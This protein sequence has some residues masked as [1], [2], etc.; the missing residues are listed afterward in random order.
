MQTH[1]VY[2]SNSSGLKVGITRGQEPITRWIDQGAIGA[3]P[4]GTVSKRL[5]AG[6][7]ETAL[8]QYVSDKTNWRIMLKGQTPSLDLYEE[9]KRFLDLIPDNHGFKPSERP[10]VE[11]RYPV[12]AYPEKIKSF[13]FDKAPLVEGTLMGIKGQYLILDTGV[14]N[15][16]KFSGYRVEVS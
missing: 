6:I 5:E 15:I 9:R 8:K 11:I 12:L 2:L 1:T 13:N 7:V 10:A 16:R 4:L 14:I 3:I